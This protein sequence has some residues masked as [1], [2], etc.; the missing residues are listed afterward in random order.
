A[1]TDAI[2]GQ[3]LTCPRAE[4]FLF[5]PHAHA[6][7]CSC[8]GR[9]G[10]PRARSATRFRGGLEASHPR[11]IDERRGHVRLT[12]SGTFVRNSFGDP[13]HHT[14]RDPPVRRNEPPRSAASRL[15]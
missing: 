14:G 10:T 13:G 2:A 12:A 6:L 9:L 7:P 8:F 3:W 11:S 1:K 15:E 4:V 5:W